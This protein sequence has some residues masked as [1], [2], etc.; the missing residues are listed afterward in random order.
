MR[1]LP[2]LDHSA[3]RA[4][5]ASSLTNDN[6]DSR[7]S[8][9]IALDALG[10]RASNADLALLSHA[11]LPKVAGVARPEH[12]RELREERGG[13]ERVVRGAVGAM[14]HDAQ[15]FA[16]RFERVALGAQ[17]AA[18]EHERVQR[19]LRRGSV[20]ERAGDDAL[21]KLQIQPW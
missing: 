13:G 21:E 6:F 5:R 11:N 2:L 17:R 10:D 19:E 15:R 20:W 1:R 9:T 14:G 18:R 12:G 7:V 16:E 8:V 4:W 3:D